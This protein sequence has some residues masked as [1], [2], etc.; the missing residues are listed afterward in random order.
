MHSHA[1]RR[2]EIGTTGA[3]YNGQKPLSSRSHAPAWERIQNTIE[4][5]T[6]I[7]ET[8]Y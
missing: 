7:Y 2:N 4:P 3:R 5:Q 6:S 1:E 8:G